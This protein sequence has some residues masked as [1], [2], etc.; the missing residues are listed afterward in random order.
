MKKRKIVRKPFIPPS[1]RE[2]LETMIAA[3][4]AYLKAIEPPPKGRPRGI[5]IP[6]REE[7]YDY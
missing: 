3:K 5:K 4:Q 6:A 1:G 7:K 2:W